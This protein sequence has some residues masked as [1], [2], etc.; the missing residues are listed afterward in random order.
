MEAASVPV[1]THV[2]TFD[3]DQANEA[4]LALKRDAIRGAGVLTVASHTPESA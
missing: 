2:Q 3:L 4:L 1:R